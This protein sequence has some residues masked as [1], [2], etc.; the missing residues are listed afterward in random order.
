MS[1]NS[2]ILVGTA[3]KTVWIKVEGKVREYLDAGVVLVWVVD[4]KQKIVHV[5]RRDQAARHL[6]ADELLTGEEVLPE[7]SLTVA[8]LCTVGSLP[9]SR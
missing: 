8:Q 4:G 2:S 5:F 7:F 3:N 6:A 9:V 1:T